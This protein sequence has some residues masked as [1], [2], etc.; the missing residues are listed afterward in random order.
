MSLHKSFLA[1]PRM[2]IMCHHSETLKW[3]NIGKTH[4]TEPN[5]MQNGTKRNLNTKRDT[6]RNERKVEY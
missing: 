1:T 4:K 2:K 6:K 5:G 3:Q